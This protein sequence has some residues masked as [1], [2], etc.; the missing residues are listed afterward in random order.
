RSCFTDRILIH[1]P[2]I[3]GMEPT[4][5]SADEWTN[6][7]L[8]KLAGFDVTHHR[9]SNHVVDVDGDQATCDVDVSAIHQIF[10][11]DRVDTL[12]IGGRYHLKLRRENGRWLIHERSLD[13]R[14]QIGDRS[15]MDKAL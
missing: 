5:M 7:G 12:T 1:Q 10:E 13:V 2:M 3:K 4:E 8:P 14:Y 15:L 11:G 9:L 6:T